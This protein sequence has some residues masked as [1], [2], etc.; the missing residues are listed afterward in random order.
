M[1]V[2]WDYASDPSDK[3]GAVI[4]SLVERR[5]AGARTSVRSTAHAD[6]A[7]FTDYV[8]RPKVP[9]RER[10]AL[11]CAPVAA[12]PPI[13]PDCVDALDTLLHQ[14]IEMHLDMLAAGYMGQGEVA[15]NIRRSVALLLKLR[16]R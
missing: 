5:G 14:H 15:E 6:I 1:T 11:P 16:G 2:S 10:R 12:P 3:G 13:D 4:V 7:H 8:V 9:A